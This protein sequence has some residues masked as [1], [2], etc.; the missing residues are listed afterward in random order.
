MAG[1]LFQQAVL[2]DMA[3]GNIRYTGGLNCA[4]DDLERLEARLLFHLKTERQCQI[5]FV[6]E[7]SSEKWR[8]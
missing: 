3:V 5:H 2:F 6:P 7:N 1:S 8:S 4:Q